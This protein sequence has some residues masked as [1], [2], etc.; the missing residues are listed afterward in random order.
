MSPVRRY[1]CRF[2]GGLGGP[3]GNFTYEKLW[4]AFDVEAKFTVVGF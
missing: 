1:M 3:F 4:D 2:D